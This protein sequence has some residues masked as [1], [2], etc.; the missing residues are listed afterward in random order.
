MLNVFYTKALSVSTS[1][2]SAILVLAALCMHAIPLIASK[3]AFF[4]VFMTAQFLK[5]LHW[6]RDKSQTPIL[7]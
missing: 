2:Y 5:H 7:L 1:K 3:T 4:E 6:N